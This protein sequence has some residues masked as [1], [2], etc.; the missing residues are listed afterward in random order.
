MRRSTAILL[1]AIVLLIVASWGFAPEVVAIFWHVRHGLHDEGAGVRI[2]IP[3]L[4]TAIEGPSSIILMSQNGRVRTWISGA[5][6]V[7]VFVSNR[8]PAP[9]SSTETVEQWWK[10]TSDAAGREGAHETASR[11]LTLAGQQEHCH[12]FQG[13]L[14]QRGVEIWCVPD[15]SG[16]WFV[17]YT[18]PTAHV[19]QFYSVLESAEAH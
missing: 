8:V 16:G 11:A 18:G 12:E 5:Q 7:L 3:L 17:D 1:A 6:G 14:F 9:Q 4:F 2:R 19:P 10:R 15:S 13:G